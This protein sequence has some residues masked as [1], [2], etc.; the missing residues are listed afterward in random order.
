MRRAP[1]RHSKRWLHEQVRNGG[2]RLT[3]PRQVIVAMLENAQ[4][5]MSADEIYAVVHRNNPGIGL[6]TVYRTLELLARMGLINKFS[7]GDGR[8]RY[9]LQRG[10]NQ[11]HHLIC[12]GCGRVI[13]YSEC[14]DEETELMSK[15]EKQL[16]Q[17]YSF[18]I[19]THQLHF[20]GL[21]SKC[22]LKL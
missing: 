7:F 4:R 3:F 22:Q 16:S 20:Y 13:D 8:A 9:E 6:T 5:H 19:H 15:I 17:K 2:F 11:H 18:K 1:I 10:K 21:C 14:A 12:R